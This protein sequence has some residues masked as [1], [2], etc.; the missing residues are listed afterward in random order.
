MAIPI[1]SSQQKPSLKFYHEMQK[2]IQLT[3]DRCLLP[4][5]RSGV[6]AGMQDMP[7][8]GCGFVFLC[9]R[10]SD[11]FVGCPIDSVVAVAVC[12]H[13]FAGCDH[14]IMFVL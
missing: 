12:W 11:F 2:F 3:S 9:L 5:G 6:R 1:F 13:I 7:S 4:I 10:R 14:E 8:F